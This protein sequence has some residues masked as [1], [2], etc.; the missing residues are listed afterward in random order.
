MS[1][2]STLI[3]SLL[4]SLILTA[5]AQGKKETALTTLPD[6]DVY[7][8]NGVHTTLHQLAKNKVLI[9]DCWFI[10]CGPCFIALGPLHRISARYANNK[11]V[12]FI[13]ICMTDSGQVKK[14]LRQD[15]AMNTYVKSYQSLSFETNF[16]LPVYFMQ[17][18]RSTVALS[19]KMLHAT[20]NDQT[21][22]PSNA[23]NFQAYPT[24]MVFTKQGK[25]VYKETG[26]DVEDKYTQ[27][28]TTA[29]NTALADSN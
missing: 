23:F 16:T 29:I 19:S 12:S 15:T 18:C 20:M 4:L 28:L 26:F 21:N 5:S 14:F 8:I 6:I 1:K 11:D 25:Q 22:C 24:C 17:G 10:P 3:L 9:I 2:K 27:R 13:T 7:D